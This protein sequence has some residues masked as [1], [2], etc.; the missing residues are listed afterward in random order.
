MKLKK[1]TVN[2]III[3]SIFSLYM[4]YGIIRCKKEGD[5]IKLN[6]T[7]YNPQNYV[8]PYSIDSVI[9]V[10]KAICKES[11]HSSKDNSDILT[12]IYRKAVPAS[13]SYIYIY[14]YKLDLVPELYDI[15][16]TLSSYGCNN[17]KVRVERVDNC[18]G[19]G[20]KVFKSIYL[21][22]YYVKFHYETTPS[23][24]EY[25]M[26]RLIGKRLGYL[27]NMPYTKYPKELSQK[28]ILQIMGAYNPLTIDEIFEY[29]EIG[30]EEWSKENV[31]FLSGIPGF[32]MNIIYNNNNVH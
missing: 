4:F 9:G 31:T 5:V 13:H 6:F 17:T 25:D 12:Y 32:T 16:V 30:L 2:Y 26:L 10:M 28:R 3:I 19:Y 7:E 1:R 18:I 8:F 27:K 24:Q 11:I 15:K 22:N 29:P 20:V 14:K 23:I 21:T